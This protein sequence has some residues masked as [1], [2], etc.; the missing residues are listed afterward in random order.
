MAQLKSP[1]ALR[2]RGR[3]VRANLI[4]WMGG[5][6][7]EKTPLRVQRTGVI[8]HEDYR[9]EKIVFESQP[10]YFVT[11]NLYIPKTGA[12]PFPAVVQPTGHSVTAKA[13]ELYQSLSIG[14]VKYGFV[15]LTYDPLGQGERRIFFDSDL[16]DSKV[17]GTT[18]EHQLVG[19]QSLLG[20][21]SLAR[22]MVW[23]GIRAIDL[24]SELPQ[25]DAARIGVA[26]CSGGGTLTAYL[27]AIDDRVKVAAPACYITSWE[28][29]L[30][31]AGPQDAEQQ[32][33]DQLRDGFNHA[34]FLI[35]AAPK[36]Y[37]IC[38]TTEDFFPLSGAQQT[39]DEA[40]EH[41]NR[42]GAEDRI[43]WF[44]APGG[45]GMRADTRSA[46]YAWMRK[47]LQ[48]KP[49]PAPEPRFRVELE[50]DLNVTATGQV[51]TSLGGETA[52]TQNMR[53]FAAIQPHAADLPAA[54]RRLTRYQPP[55]GPPLVESGTPPTED[56]LRVE[57]LTFQPHPG[58]RV[59]AALYVPS[60]P[61]HEPV[62][63]VDAS[64][65]SAASAKEIAQA[66][67][68]VLALD[69][70]GLGATADPR[71]SYSAEWFPQDKS[72]WLALMVGHTIT[73]LRMA[74]ITAALDLLAARQL[75]SGGATLFARGNPGVAALHIAV[76]EPRLQKLV[77]EDLPP[78]Y[79]TLATTPIHKQIFDVVVPD[80]LRHYDLP[81]LAAAISPR[82]VV[83][84]RSVPTDSTASSAPNVRTVRRRELTSIP[85][86]YFRP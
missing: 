47:W 63:V 9:V 45:H 24:I 44:T 59:P 35:A 38:S 5:L 49:G 18:V 8:D 83:L 72:I 78:A 7:G 51:S 85:E 10:R 52:S 11:A 61:L 75:L 6:P 37:L 65:R 60:A 56:T 73:G 54:V 30:K 74:D 76:L 70:A 31:K 4:R 26:G 17:G 36:P 20:G 23:D 77:L 15:V 82:A 42:F 29:Q 32:F 16:R 68:I 53:R 21:E 39:F 1:V 25:V 80:V 71:Q 62:I 3:Q 55:S 19:V 69:A 40:K 81:A 34:D 12:G 57:H 50:E 28:E 33:P 79:R 43:S 48:Q 13:R 22:Q 66:G 14:L 86:A 67:H 84:G 2:E 58:R 64:G 27:A 41:Y 46:I